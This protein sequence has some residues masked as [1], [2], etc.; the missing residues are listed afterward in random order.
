M[1]YTIVQSNEEKI[2]PQCVRRGLIEL[3]TIE[4]GNTEITN[5][6]DRVVVV[7]ARVALDEYLTYAAYICQ[8]HRAF[9][10]C[11]RMAFYT[12][13]S[14]DRR[15]PKILGSIESISRDEIETRTDLTESDRARL[16][17]L[18]EKMESSRSED[19]RKYQYKVV[20]LTPPDSPETLTLPYN[21]VNDAPAKSG[22][23]TAFTQGQ[24]YVSLAR[25]AQEPK[26]TSSLT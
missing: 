9:R 4:R 13:N 11:V 19:W 20:F 8:P 7:A 3:S 1:E 18:H 15:I 2:Q 24:R 25:L 22:R 17:A 26:T 5:T 23:G 6:A 10:D 14:I 12:K 21:I 16:R